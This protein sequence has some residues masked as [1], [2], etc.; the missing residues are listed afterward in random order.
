M[1]GFA[2]VSAQMLRG[3]IITSILFSCHFQL[4]VSLVLPAVASS[5]KMDHLRYLKCGNQHL[6]WEI[7]GAMVD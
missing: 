1:E 3:K 2:N 7:C 5:F 4:L 6:S